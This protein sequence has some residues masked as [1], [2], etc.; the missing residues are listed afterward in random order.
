[1][2]PEQKSHASA[3]TYGKCKTAVNKKTASSHNVADHVNKKCFESSNVTKANG[4]AD[5]FDKVESHV[6]IHEH[7][8]NTNRSNPESKAIMPIHM[9]E[10]DGTKYDLSKPL[11]KNSQIVIDQAKWIDEELKLAMLGRDLSNL[12]KFVHLACCGVVGH[13]ELQIKTRKVLINVSD[14]TETT[15]HTLKDFESTAKSALSA[16]KVAYDYLKDNLE[17]EAFKT[18]YQI[19]KLS[20]EMH[21]ISESLSTK[22]NKESENVNNLENET[23]KKKETTITDKEETDRLAKVNSA[24]KEYES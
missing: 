16:I 24:E 12:G 23:L 6:S 22:C 3:P 7:T 1:M 13:A 9:V 20:E 15:Y 10:Y 21:K 17:A 2:I 19:Q 4:V 5:N 11:S 14:I 8:K 18:F